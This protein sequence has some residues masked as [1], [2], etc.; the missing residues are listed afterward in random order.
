MQRILA[1]L[2]LTL[3]VTAA[4]P[5]EDKEEREGGI[6]GTGI[7]GTVTELGSIYVNGQHV[8]FDDALPVTSPLGGRLA[9]S[10]VPGETVVVE[11]DRQESAWHA[12]SIK[13]YLPIV[14]PVASVAPRHIEVMGAVIE[15]PDNAGSL[16]AFVGNAVEAGDWVAVSG[17][18][19]GDAVAASRIETI[20]ALPMASVVGTYRADPPAVRVGTVRLRGVALEHARPLDVLT[21]QGTP[22]PD[23]LEVAA[24]A[25]GL[26]SGPVGEVLFEGYLSEP[27]IEGAYTVQGSGLLAYVGSPGMA[28]DPS[29]GL[30]CGDPQ[31]VTTIERVLDLPEAASAREARLQDLRADPPLPCLDPSGG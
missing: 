15:I 8:T 16:A 31:G 29:R 26:F 9:S 5:A 20:A 22:T 11:A 10:L 1:F 23:G 18:W 13:A 3:L 27:D 28:V 17:L 4:S 6:V 24:V 12:R 2:C 14:G 25:I 7:V 30:F 19:K 21:S